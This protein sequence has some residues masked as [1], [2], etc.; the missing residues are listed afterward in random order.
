MRKILAA[1]AAIVL[2]ARTRAAGRCSSATGLS[3]A[4]PAVSTQASASR[5]ASGAGKAHVATN[6]SG[7]ISTIDAQTNIRSRCETERVARHSSVV[8][9]DRLRHQ[10]ALHAHLRRHELAG[11]G[12]HGDDLR[13]ERGPRWRRILLWRP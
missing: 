4:Q 9:D 1:F 2:S 8:G 11:H 6:C 7:S 10:H 5:A 12:E 3:T 13:V